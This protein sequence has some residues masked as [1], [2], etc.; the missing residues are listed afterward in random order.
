MQDIDDISEEKRNV[1]E[2]CIISNSDVRVEVI[3]IEEERKRTSSF[4]KSH[5]K[6]KFE[7]IE[8]PKYEPSG[9]AFEVGMINF[10]VK[11]NDQDVRSSFIDRNRQQPICMGG[12]FQ[13]DQKLK[14]KTVCR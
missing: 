2:D 11:S 3:D 12:D 10:L 5:K 14:M 6:E 9:S 8:S 1:I 13:F 7:P 4:C